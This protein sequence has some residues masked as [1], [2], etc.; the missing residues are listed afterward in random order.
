M[1]VP[2]LQNLQNF[3]VDEVPLEDLVPFEDSAA[4]APAAADLGNIQLGFVETFVPPVDPMQL[5]APSSSK[6]PSVAAI[7][8]WAKYFSSVDRSLPTVSI[9]TE[10]VDFF[11]MLMLK[12]GTFEWA[13]QFLT[14]P[15]WATITKMSAGNTFSF[16]LLQPLLQLLSLN[17]HALILLR[18]TVLIWWMRPMILDPR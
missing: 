15:A 12:P 17:F 18:S 1:F 7:R 13:Q 9:A 4:Q 6:G 2:N 16:S 14:S 10:W 11:T 5:S 3:I 8:C